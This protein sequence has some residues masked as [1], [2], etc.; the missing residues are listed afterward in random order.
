M[1]ILSFQFKNIP[2]L[3]KIIDVLNLNTKL[4]VLYFNK[5]K[6]AWLRNQAF[7]AKFTAILYAIILM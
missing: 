1:Y 3:E 6:K 7:C 4:E 2:E 5:H